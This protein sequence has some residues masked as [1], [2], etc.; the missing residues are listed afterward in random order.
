ME[1]KEKNTEIPF[2]EIEF[3]EL[4]TLKTIAEKITADPSETPELFFSQIKNST[5][6]IPQRIQDALM[7]FKMNH[8]MPGIIILKGIT[9][10]DSEIPRTPFTNNEQIGEKTIL[11]KIQALLLSVIGEMVAYEAEGYGRLFQDIVPVESCKETQT[12]LGSAEL[13]IHTEQAFS[14]LKPDILSLACLKGDKNA[15]T[16]ILPLNSILNNINFKEY[17]LLRKPLWKT[18]VDLSFKLNCTEFIDGDVR[19]PLSI[20]NGSAVT[21]TLIFDQDLMSGVTEESDEMIQRII[22]I[23]YKE[24]LSYNLVEGDIMFIE[25]NRTVHGRSSFSPKYDG[26]DRFLIRCFGTYDYKKSEYAREKGLR[27]ISAIYS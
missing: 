7:G 15:L 9:F 8:F 5:H 23:Y 16:Y 13:E 24:R 20:I 4:V 19:G 25:N 21:P 6:E 11:S 18:G 3:S 14:K 22:D 12:S 17:C 10:D 26:N 2:F 1:F 27:M